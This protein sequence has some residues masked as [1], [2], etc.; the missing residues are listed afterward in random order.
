M[1][2]TNLTSA[3]VFT[4]LTCTQH[5]HYAAHPPGCSERMLGTLHLFFASVI[6]RSFKRFNKMQVVLLVLTN[7]SLI[8]DLP[9]ISRHI[10]L[11]AVHRARNEQYSLLGFLADMPLGLLRLEC[12]IIGWLI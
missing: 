12:Q 7:Q 10:S 3:D 9:N 2:I 6:M 11:A 5:R 8:N 1:S 4:F